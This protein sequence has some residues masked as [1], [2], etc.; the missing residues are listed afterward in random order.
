MRTDVG[1]F[2]VRDGTSRDDSGPVSVEVVGHRLGIEGDVASF[3]GIVFL[4]KLVF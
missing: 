2:N 4:L 3:V 1:L